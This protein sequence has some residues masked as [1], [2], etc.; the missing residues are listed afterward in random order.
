DDYISVILDRSPENIRAFLTRHA[1]LEFEEMDPVKSTMLLEMQR[2]AMLMYTSCAWFF[3]EISGLETVQ[4]LRYAARA[5]EIAENF[6]ET[7]LE[8]Q[9]LERLK[10]AR[11]NEVEYGDGARV[12]SKLVKPSAVSMERSAFIYAVD[13]LFEKHP[14]LARIFCF[15][16]NRID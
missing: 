8:E 4:A 5:I 7:D 16:V 2:N 3:S 13:L 1:K 6:T 11:S 10:L 14:K 12:Y 9:L 15:D